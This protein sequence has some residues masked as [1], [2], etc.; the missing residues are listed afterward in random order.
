MTNRSL[1]IS[2]FFA[3]SLA[4]GQVERIEA[5]FRVYPVLKIET[6]G[7]FYQPQPNAEMLELRFRSGDRS[8]VS[9]DYVGPPVLQF[10]RENGLNEDG[11]MQYRTVGQV[12][13]DKPEMLIFFTKATKTGEEGMEFS[14]L[15]LD[16]GP[17]GLPMDHVAFLNF[18]PAPF[19]CRFMDKDFDIPPG[20]QPPISVAKKLNEDIFIGL[21]VRNQNTHRVVLK[22]R[23]QFHKGNR[24]Y[25]LLLPP[26]REGSFRIRAYRVTEFVGEKQRFNADWTPPQ[27]STSFNASR[28]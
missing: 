28:L 26:T 24:H 15:A 22:N 2:L 27:S 25:I 12:T 13:L 7:I 5:E 20:A 3:S 19:V 17:G 16:D 10:Y 6:E 14:L 18:T 23:W 11:E 9:Y 1:I 21:A 8:A 4:F